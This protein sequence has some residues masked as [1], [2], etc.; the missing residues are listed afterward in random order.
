MASLI[1]VMLIIHSCSL[2][3]PLPFR[4]MRQYQ[5]DISTLVVWHHLKLKPQQD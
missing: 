4:L 2:F 5:P 3:F 1:T